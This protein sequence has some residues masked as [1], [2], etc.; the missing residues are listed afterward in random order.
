MKQDWVQSCIVSWLELGHW[1]HGEER[2]SV[3]P[4]S[5]V[6][7]FVLVTTLRPVCT[8]D[9]RSDVFFQF[10]RKHSARLLSWWFRCCHLVQWWCLH[11][12]RRTHFNSV[13]TGFN[14]LPFWRAKLHHK[15]FQLVVWRWTGENEVG[16]CSFQLERHSSWPK[17]VTLRNNKALLCGITFSQAS[18]LFLLSG[19]T[20]PTLTL[21][22][23]R[24]VDSGQSETAKCTYQR[25]LQRF[26]HSSSSRQWS[27]TCSCAESHSI[28]Q[29]TW[30]CPLLFCLSSH[31]WCF[32]CHQNQERRSL[33]E[34]QC[35]WLSLFWCSHSQ[36]TFLR[37]PTHFQS[38]VREFISGG[39]VSFQVKIEQ[40][41][42]GW[43]P[44]VPVAQRRSRRVVLLLSGFYLMFVM[45]S[46]AVWLLITVAI[47][48]VHHHNKMKRP[49]SWL[50]R[51]VLKQL[52]RIM[53]MRLV[54]FENNGSNDILTTGNNVASL[55]NNKNKTNVWI[56]MARVF[57][58]LCLIVFVLVDL[59]A[60]I[61]L[62]CHYPRPISVH[63]RYF[64]RSEVNWNLTDFWCAF[65][66]SHISLQS[67]TDRWLCVQEIKA[68]QR[69]EWTSVM[70][71]LHLPNEFQKALV[72]LVWRLFPE[73][74]LF[75][76][77]SWHFTQ[78]TTQIWSN[79][80]FSHTFLHRIS[81][82]SSLAHFFTHFFWDLSIHQ[83][84][85]FDLSSLGN[86]FPSETRLHFVLFLP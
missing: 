21:L 85:H 37:A 1:D 3:A 66:V 62:M 55:D 2:G 14:V 72:S 51:L 8:R 25:Q 48:N 52:A 75:W 46:T 20:F 80:C 70:F 56:L 28:T 10:Q 67:L 58:R 42:D 81:P 32:G 15:D 45:N 59:L 5:A 33:L 65:S 24:K 74:P 50:Q 18:G 78:N 76:L 38:S 64:P 34:S 7:C 71:I 16:I 27:I 19:T 44:T 26:I 29:C 73:T 17:S 69:V 63:P 9:H 23:I 6:N 43:S 39:S 47:L 68:K 77:N 30:L 40:L 79:L 57:D 61:V 41:R 12:V 53:C 60:F 11:C 83:P 22:D 35:S 54:V 82:V 36:M 84:F 13:L 49:P 31:C 86:F 4:T